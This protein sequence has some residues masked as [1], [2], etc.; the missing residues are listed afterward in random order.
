MLT[1]KDKEKLASEKASVEI[2]LTSVRGRGAEELFLIQMCLT[3]GEL[4]ALK[5]ALEANPTMGKDV[6]AY[7][8]NALY[9]AEISF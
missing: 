3:N 6:Q 8:N 9:R 5:N 4:L 1:K 2:F 7:L